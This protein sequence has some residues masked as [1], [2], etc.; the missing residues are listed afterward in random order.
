MAAASW[1]AA[2]V[3]ACEGFIG[4]PMVIRL[5]DDGRKSATVPG[6]AIAPVNVIEPLTSRIGAA[7]CQQN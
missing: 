2:A 1:I 5:G 4:I 7:G 6:G 3:S